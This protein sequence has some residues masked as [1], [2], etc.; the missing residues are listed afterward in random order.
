M[1]SFGSKLS[2]LYPLSVLNGKNA[3]CEFTNISLFIRDLLNIKS[4]SPTIFKL[5]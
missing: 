3:E 4:Y 2:M 5:F 1:G